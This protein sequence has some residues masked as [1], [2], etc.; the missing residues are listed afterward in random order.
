MEQVD[1]DDEQRITMAYRWLLSRS[2]DQHELQRFSHYVSSQRDAF[3][4][5]LPAARAITTGDA[6]GSPAQ[7][8]VWTLVCGALLNCDEALTRP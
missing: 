4:T 1:G 8:A 2:P 3:A 6:N 7:L 5:D